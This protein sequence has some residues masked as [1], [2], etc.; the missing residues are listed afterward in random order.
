MTVETYVLRVWNPLDLS[1]V[2]VRCAGEGLWKRTWALRG[3]AAWDVVIA[4]GATLYRTRV[5]RRVRH[6][7]NLEASR[8]IRIKVFY[9]V[10]KLPLNS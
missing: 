6:A 3:R 5:K 7:W 1:T 8:K 10:T 4:K 2:R 9:K